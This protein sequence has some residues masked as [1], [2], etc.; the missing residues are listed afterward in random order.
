[1]WISEQKG[2]F[3]RIRHQLI[4]KKKWK[5]SSVNCS[6][7]PKEHCLLDGSHAWSICPSGECN[8]EIGRAQPFIWCGQFRQNLVCMRA[9][10]IVH[11][12]WRMNNNTYNYKTVHAFSHKVILIP[13]KKYRK[14]AN[15][16]I[17][18]IPSLR[19]VSVSPS[20]FASKRSI[21]LSAL[22]ALLWKGFNDV[23]PFQM[24]PRAT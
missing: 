18:R 10:W 5:Y 8:K 21:C 3:C 9:S 14:H 4:D 6:W 20:D 11:T 24:S 15:G 22:S 16:K 13:T 19:T 17:Y 12:K 2:D 23:V 1:M 7:Y